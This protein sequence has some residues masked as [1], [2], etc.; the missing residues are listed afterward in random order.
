MGNRVKVFVVDDSSRVRGMVSTA[1]EEVSSANIFGTY[2]AVDARLLEA[3][4]KEAEDDDTPILVILDID[5]PDVDGIEAVSYLKNFGDNV[6]ILVMCAP[7]FHD[8]KR[9]LNAMAGGAD[10]FMLKYL[11]TEDVEKSKLFVNALKTL[12]TSLYGGTVAAQAAAPT[13]AA[14]VNA[15]V[16]KKGTL[17]PLPKPFLP[18][19]LA[20]ASS[21]GGPKALSTLFEELKGK[22]VRMPV[23]ITQHMPKDFTGVFAKQLAAVSGLMVKEAED[24]EEVKEGTIYVAAGDYHMLLEKTAAGV[25]KI[26]LDQGPLVNFCRPAADPMLSSL[27]EVYGGQN[28]LLT[29]LTGMGHDGLDGAEQLIAAGGAVISQDEAS[30]VVWGMPGAVANAGATMGI[31][32]LEGIIPRIRELVAGKLT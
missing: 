19:V 10:D 11:P 15:P 2:N 23:F 3:I 6:K 9:Q 7:Q 12:I 27:I 16:D 22:Q 24:G 17:A 8:E 30:S 14:S 26:K 1:L 20:I 18:K 4:A 13:A 29:V 28:I 31:Y 32:P 21:T 25:V 5:M